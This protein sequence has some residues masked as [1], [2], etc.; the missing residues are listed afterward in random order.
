MP[1]YPF[2]PARPN[3]TIVLW[4]NGFGLAATTLT[5]GSSSQNSQ[6]P[7]LPIV[8]IGGVTATVTFAGVVGPGLYQFNVTVPGS[9]PDGDSAISASYRGVQT[10]A[11]EP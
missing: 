7:E 1:G 8:Q 6:L 5:E 3:E 4:A 9:V 11:R 2:T 10:S